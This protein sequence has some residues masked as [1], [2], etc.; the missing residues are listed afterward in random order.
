MNKVNLSYFFTLFIHIEY[1]L[2]DKVAF[3]FAVIKSQDV[4]LFHHEFL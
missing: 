4:I 2:L 3:S 1:R